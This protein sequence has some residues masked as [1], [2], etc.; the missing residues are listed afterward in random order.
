MGNHSSYLEE[1]SSPSAA[2]ANAGEGDE[3]EMQD[4]SELSSQERWMREQERKKKK[5]KLDRLKKKGIGIYKT[6]M[7]S[8]HSYKYD[9]YM[10]YDL[11]GDSSGQL[12]KTRM[13]KMKWILNKSCKVTTMDYDEA[14]AKY[15]DILACERRIQQAISD[16]CAFLVVMTKNYVRI[17]N[18]T[19]A[20]YSPGL[21]SLYLSYFAADESSS[22]SSSS[23]SSSSG[24][25]SN[26]KALL[27]AQIVSQLLTES[28]RLVSS[29]NTVA[30]E[31]LLM[32]VIRG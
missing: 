24:S 30:M 18:E 10:S 2:S 16:C 23:G 5:E 27:Q 19:F 15:I 6:K 14:T 21:Q 7:V 11:G 17:V 26:K 28:S 9:V 1:S 32:S 4:E 29:S 31:F 12:V 13:K 20:S 22:S 8:L 25:S 3:D